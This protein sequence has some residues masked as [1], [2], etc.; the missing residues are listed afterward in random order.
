M[1]IS[2]NKLAIAKATKIFKSLGAHI[3]PININIPSHCLLMKPINLKFKQFLEKIIINKPKIKFINNINCN[4]DISSKDIKSTLIKQ[5]YS[6]INWIKCIKF[7]EKQNI[8][9]LIEFTPKNL[10]KKISQQITNNLN[11]NSI[12]NVE[13]FFST[14]NKYKI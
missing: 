5:L 1:T 7:I 6:P 10:L 11:I 4:Y 13:T 12:Y 9:N 2:G 14:L 3:I 8:S